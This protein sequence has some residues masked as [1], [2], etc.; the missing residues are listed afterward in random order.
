M[1]NRDSNASR[2]I[3][4]VGVEELLYGARPEPFQRGTESQE[5]PIIE[6]PQRRRKASKAN[7]Y[8]EGH[9]KVFLKAASTPKLLL[10]SRNSLDDFQDG[11]VADQS[12]ENDQ[13][14]NLSP[15]S[16]EL[17]SKLHQVHNE[18]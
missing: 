2:N 9:C 13:Q 10:R 11:T 5:V 1:W 18:R 16:M 7:A 4:I 12:T 3:R 15:A 8:S 6:T 17:H 14:Q